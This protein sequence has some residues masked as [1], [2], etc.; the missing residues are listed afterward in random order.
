M[1][2]IREG[3]KVRETSKEELKSCCWCL[4][5]DGKKIN[6]VEHQAVVLKNAEKE[7]KLKPMVLTDGK[8]CT[9]YEGIKEVL[10]EY[11]LWGS[12]KMIVSD[13]TN[14]NTEK[15]GGVVARI[16]NEMEQKDLTN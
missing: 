1:A 6:G 10:D 4:H 5:F 11:D 9:I 16:Q 13:T 3:Q 8:S 12:I 7:I 15:Y 14:V 2:L